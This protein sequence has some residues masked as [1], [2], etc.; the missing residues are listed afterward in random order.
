MQAR[1]GAGS[2]SDNRAP[3][4]S[5][6]F[7]L[8]RIIF[9][10]FDAF[11]L[12]ILDTSYPHHRQISLLKNS[13]IRL[14]PENWAIGGNRSIILIAG[15]VF[16]ILINDYERIRRIKMKGHHERRAHRRCRFLSP[17]ICT[18]FNSDRFYHAKTTNHSREGINFVSDFPFKSGASIYVRI[19]YQ[20]QDG[21][22]EGI[23]C[24]GG[25]RIIGLAE[26]KWCREIL[27]DYGRFYE[28]GLKYQEPAL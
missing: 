3:N 12:L 5:P 6:P 27:R 4:P 23:C 16:A 7:C 17:V 15:I 8:Y 19:D 11:F 28:I 9:L 25:A 1:S 14:N 18:H 22:W 24:C 26:V 13:L 20:S 10:H 21:G 2:D